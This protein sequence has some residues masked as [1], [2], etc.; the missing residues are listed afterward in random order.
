MAAFQFSKNVSTI[1]HGP[2]A[3][4]DVRDVPDDVAARY[5]RNNWGTILATPEPE[6]VVKP[7]RAA[8]RKTV[9]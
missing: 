6:P 5:E 8:R 1:W 2:C 3:P 9:D 4:G 7:K